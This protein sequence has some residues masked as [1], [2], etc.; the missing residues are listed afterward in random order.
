MTQQAESGSG[1]VAQQGPPDGGESIPQAVDAFDVKLRY[2]TCESPAI[3]QVCYALAHNRIPFVKLISILVVDS[4]VPKKLTISVSGEWAVNAR[5]PIRE[6]TFIL[7]APGPGE[8]IEADGHEI[9]LNDVALADLE[10]RAP[11]TL[12]VQVADDLGRSQKVRFDLDIY[13]RDQWLSHPEIAVVTAAFVQPN[14]PDVNRVLAR[15]GEILKRSGASGISGY[16]RAESG[17]HH[18]IAEAVFIALQ[19]FV[20]TYIN[21]PASYETLGQKLRPIDRVLDERQ[22]TCIDL[23]CAYASCLEQAG[24]HPV[25]FMVRGHAFSGYINGEGSLNS[26][27]IGQW[28]AIKSLLD[29]NLIIGVETVAIPEGLSFDVAKGS[30]G[31]HL[32]S[33]RMQSVIDV[34]KAHHEGV[35]PLPARVL[36]DNVVTVVIDNGP[37]T[38]PIVERRDPTTRKLLADSVPA[39]VQSWKNALLDLS[40]RNR[41]LNL[42]PE[43]HGISLIAPSGQLGWIEDQLNDGSPFVI[44]AHDA[45]NALQRQVAGDDL[46]R[47]AR[48][49]H[50]PPEMLV[51]AAKVARTIFTG[52]ETKRFKS[53]VSRQRSE[54]RLQEEES[55]ANSLYMTLG[56]VTWGPKYGD[57]VSPVFLVPIRI[58]KLRGIDAAV[59]EMD[60]TQTSSVNYCLIEALRLREHLALQWFSDDMSDDLG[61]NVE[62]GLEALR[63][64][65]RE[66]GLDQN[67]FSV[68]QTA[69]IALLDFEKF[70]L[71]RDLT[72]HWKDFMKRPV[73]KHLVE[74]SRETFKDP[75]AEQLASLSISDTTTICAQP[76]DGSQ[77]RAI[78]RALAGSSFVLQGPPGSGKSQTITNLLA[79]AMN[80]GKKVL[81]VAEKQAALQEVQE[82]L[83]AVKLGPYCLVLHDSGTKPERLREQ[84]RE[85]LDQ[86]PKLEEKVHRSFEERFA[87]AAHQLDEYRQNVYSPNKAGFSFARSYYRLGELGEGITVEVPRSILEMDLESVSELQKNLLEIDDI[88]RPAQVRPEHPWMLVGD[89]SFESLNRQLLGGEITS[90]LAACAALVPAATGVM[91]EA[92]AAVS[93]IDGLT[94]LANV[95]E[96]REL[97]HLP[98]SGE[99][100]AISSAGWRSNVETL[101][102]E[103]ESV[104]DSVARDIAGKETILRRTDLDAA[105]PSIGEAAKSFALGRK[106]RVREALGPF[107]E[108]VDPESI[109]PGAV[110][111]KVGRVAEASKRV[112]AISASLSEMKGLANLLNDAPVTATHVAALRVRADLLGSIAIAIGA[113]GEWARSLRAVISSN[114]MFAPGLSATVRS[115]GQSLGAVFALLGSNNHTLGRWSSGIGL[116]RAAHERSR[117]TWEDAVKTGSLLT[118]QRWIILRT[119]MKAYR[120]A[121]L[122][123]LCEAIEDGSLPA[124]E[125]AVAFERGLLF[126]TLQVR[127]EETNL[128][129][130]DSVAHNSKVSRFI[131]LLNERRERAQTVIPYYLYKTRTINAGVT[132]GKVGEFRKE[133]NTPAKRRRGKSIRFLIERYPEIISDLTPCFL[134]SPDSVAQFLPPGKIDFDIVV[135]DE[136]SQIVVADS[137]GALGRAKSCVIVGDSKQMPPTK[138]GMVDA[139][140]DEALDLEVEGIIA[141][142]ESIL[143]EA[144]MAGF[145]QELLT[146]HYRSQDESLIAFSNEHYYDRR[147]STF[148]ASVQFRPDCGVFYRRVDGQFD[149]GKTRTNEIEA[150]AIIEE[151]VKRLDDPVTAG[152]SYGIVT[153]NIQQRNLIT[154]LLD[155][156]EHP[157]VRELR[158]TEDKKRRLFVLNL[159]NVQGRER[160]VIILGTA[161]SKRVGG[162]DMP[163]N[164]GPLT[165]L[166]GERRLNVAV[167]RAK[168]QFVV[169]SSFD[170]EE[171]RLAKSLG[172]VHLRDYL[173]AARRREARE[174]A[175]SSGQYS[176]TPQIA[177]VAE[178]LRER[179]VKVEVGMGLS[180]FK[181]DMALTL[182]EFEDRWLV[183]V[184]FDGEEW[185]ERP[186]AIDRDALPIIVLENVMN[187]RRVVRVWMPSLRIELDSVIDE[188][189]EHVQVAK[190]LPEP[191]PPP[192]PPP[193]VAKQ[194]EN[195]DGSVKGPNSTDKG[196]EKNSKERRLEPDEALPNQET[197]KQF[198]F[199]PVPYDSGALL[200]TYAQGLLEQLVDAEGPMLASSA[201]KR[202][203]YEFGLQRVR[204]ARVAELYQL[205]STRKVTQLLDEH[206]VWPADVQPATWRAFRRTTKEQR[207][208]DEIS[209]YEIVNAL[210]VTVKRSITISPEELVSWAGEFFGAGRIT[211]KVETYL[212]ACIRWAIEIKR[213][214]LEQGQLTLGE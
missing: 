185:S 111:S 75:V 2:A 7:D 61:L 190:D 38:A 25:I 119:G 129:V 207:K 183:A 73:V 131:Q 136:A 105:L 114:E 211:E 172:M 52:I 206:Y 19:E 34:A 151:L 108:I 57:Y 42:R 59:V 179:G 168:R 165:N 99:W 213:L 33:E 72:D 93:E 138:F 198:R 173:I 43:R 30:V 23:A 197:F 182:Q 175:A 39:R 184:L 37:Q 104:L 174:R 191:T 92:I 50:L 161:F 17:Q 152:L 162:G 66:K 15:A 47:G 120:D 209:P 116:V 45:L 130:F 123:V 77:I 58:N 192:P 128:D 124:D 32:N 154:E 148:P 96:L 64:E 87:A 80:R 95:L 109:E 199:P 118:L 150:R 28:T 133:V 62:A 24:L 107:G 127:A 8:T 203:A 146:W 102:K 205:L 160:D 10:E 201:I 36:R 121:G 214:H 143:E 132:T 53:V 68:D 78:E 212:K 134:M 170:P 48:A 177:Q 155:Q 26:S 164:F 115:V 54:A 29:S 139:I 135:F 69:S 18:R 101:L 20:K 84:L 65:F 100:Q 180:N 200:T 193:P 106:K 125:A 113:A 51:E 9:Q 22:G 81:F 194:S 85:A 12:I 110:V 3:P 91:S 94:T 83:E 40:F 16:Q 46:G 188:L 122:A 71:W 13:A 189:V 97:G 27:V 178:K 89:I 163:L 98:P 4:S 167:T 86:Q 112:R 169:V 11:A 204:D 74:T 67:G 31:M 196:E 186:L 202:V 147:L 49:Q 88:T 70:R 14:H 55:G 176:V 210:E 90:A 5:S 156:H 44:A 158:E 181:I 145:H 171:M 76:A 142:E 149:H 187:W 6:R 117:Q 208:I 126:T 56:S 60:A 63:K 159:E 41:L 79:N 35:R 1:P 137:I 195:D 82:R 153:L 166:G 21:P 103:Y 141:E 157:R 140:D 144:V